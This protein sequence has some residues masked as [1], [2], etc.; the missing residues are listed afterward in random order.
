[1]KLYKLTRS[2]AEA[3]IPGVTTTSSAIFLTDRKMPLARQ[4][5]V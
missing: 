3:I 2:I 1:M 4:N 5:E